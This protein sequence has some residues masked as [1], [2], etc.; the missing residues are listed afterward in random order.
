MRH[1]EASDPLSFSFLPEL[2]FLLL[3]LTTMP[4]SCSSSPLLGLL[5]LTS[6]PS[7]SSQISPSLPNFLSISKSLS[8][9]SPR[10]SHDFS[11]SMSYGNQIATRA[12]PSNSEGEEMVD[13]VAQQLR[14]NSDGTWVT[15]NGVVI[16]QRWISILWPLMTANLG[17]N[18]F[19]LAFS[20]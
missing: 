10:L 1:L 18:Q 13:P 19:F 17:A 5:H 16:T 3:Q 8:L 14:H 6:F 11:W 2:V 12:G 20:S 15:R 9:S 4:W 7:F